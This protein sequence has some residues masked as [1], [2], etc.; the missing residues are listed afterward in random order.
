MSGARRERRDSSGRLVYR[1]RK[2]ARGESDLAPK[3][4]RSPRPRRL[5]YPDP[6][7]PAKALAGVRARV[8]FGEQ[9]AVRSWP[10]ILEN[11]RP[12]Q[13]AP[14]SKLESSIACGAPRLNARNGWP[15][16]SP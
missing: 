8:G 4:H 14:G 16:L 3:A 2:P 11:K 5:L 9:L 10:M 15:P 6:R 1:P 13:V 7:D 12:G